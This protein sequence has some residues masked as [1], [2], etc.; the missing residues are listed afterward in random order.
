LACFQEDK[1]TE[2][3]PTIN[4]LNVSDDVRG[5]L[6]T[7]K[8]IAEEYDTLEN[9]IGYPIQDYWKISTQ[10]I[11]PMRRWIEGENASVICQEHGLFE[12]N[13][14]R[15]VMK[16]TNMLD[17]WLAMATYCQHTGQINKIIEVRKKMIRDIVISD[18]L[19]LHL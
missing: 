19:Y 18:S 10:T 9:K 6:K 3:S 1:A 7:L 12:G 16:M 11:E 5:A 13:F 8:K 14:I 2:D 15:A 17:E 4:E